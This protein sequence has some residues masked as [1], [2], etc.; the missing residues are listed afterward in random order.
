MSLNAALNATVALIEG[1]TILAKEI[2]RSPG[3][4][5]K[6]VPEILARLDR[7]VNRSTIKTLH[8]ALRTILSVQPP[9]KPADLTDDDLYE[10]AF[11]MGVA[12]VEKVLEYA[13]DDLEGR[14][15]G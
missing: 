3:S 9:P 6:N 13:V 12:M 2:L 4:D 11:Y 15:E 8:S 7:A 10:Y 1:R 5:V 14:T